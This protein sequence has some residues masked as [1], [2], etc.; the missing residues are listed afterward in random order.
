MPTR[1][2][3]ASASLTT[4]VGAALEKRCAKRPPFPTAVRAQLHQAAAPSAA[5]R[6]RDAR[7]HDCSLAIA[8]GQPFT[9]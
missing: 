8:V 5:S 1:G 9:P 7:S 3:P 2:L 4:G 6:L